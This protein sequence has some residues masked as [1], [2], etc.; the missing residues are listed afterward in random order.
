[1]SENPWK[2]THQT[3]C[4]GLNYVPPAIHVLKAPLWDCIGDGEVKEV[5]NIK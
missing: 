4:Y 5:V 1:M 3:W 2:A